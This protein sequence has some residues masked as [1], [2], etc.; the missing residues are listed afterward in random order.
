MNKFLVVLLLPILS[1]FAQVSQPRVEPTG[2]LYYDVKQIQLSENTLSFQMNNDTKEK[3]SVLLAGALSLVVPGAGQ[4]YNE[5]YWAAGVYALIEAGVIYMAI[6]YNNDGD[7][8]ESDFEKF[9]ETHWSAKAYAQYLYSTTPT[10]FKQNP[11][12]NDGSVNW[13][14]LN[15]AELKIT[16]FSHQL[17]PFGDQQYYEMIG[18]YNQFRSGWDAFYLP[19]D[20]YHSEGPLKI[21]VNYMGMRKDANDAYDISSKFVI[22]IYLNH[23]VST[24]HAIWETVKFNK[25]LDINSN[26]KVKTVGSVSDYETNLNFRY[27]F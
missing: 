26:V 13:D 5:N 14:V 6:K 22:A 15:D 2:N 8:K 1:V 24:V 16:G 11:V 10:S 3:R 20:D 9:A 27:S 23:V 19:G 21:A 17:A 25:S 7:T 12:N 4:A 18:K